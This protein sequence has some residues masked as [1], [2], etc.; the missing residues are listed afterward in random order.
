MYA[1]NYYKGRWGKTP[2][3]KL[4]GCQSAILITKLDV[5]AS[6]GVHEDSSP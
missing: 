6:I 3:V 1:H 4:S 2:A 5:P